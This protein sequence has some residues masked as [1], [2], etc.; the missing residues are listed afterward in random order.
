MS[1]K[2]NWVKIIQDPDPHIINADP[3]HYPEHTKITHLHSTHTF[4]FTDIFFLHFA[5]QPFLDVACVF[6][7]C[8]CV[9]MSFSINK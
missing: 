6:L 1:W 5:H 8:M 7:Q 2:K 4:T 3:K 9:G